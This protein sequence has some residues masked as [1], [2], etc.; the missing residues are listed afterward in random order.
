MT[1]K[2]AVTRAP[3]FVTPSD[4][5][6][7][8][9]TFTGSFIVGATSRFSGSLLYGTPEEVLGFLGTSCLGMTKRAVTSWGCLP[10]INA[11]RIATQ[12]RSEEPP[13]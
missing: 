4:T 7:V 8:I 9:I 13:Q 3:L 12:F 11:H 10:Y 2:N 1:S 5:D 6:W